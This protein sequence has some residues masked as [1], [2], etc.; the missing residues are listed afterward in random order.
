MIISISRSKTTQNTIYSIQSKC[1]DN[2]LWWY[3]NCV[4]FQRTREHANSIK[5]VNKKLDS[6]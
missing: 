4:R 3:Y 1:I 6:S 2:I 5:G